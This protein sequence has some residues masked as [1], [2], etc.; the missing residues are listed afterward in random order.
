MMLSRTCVSTSIRYGSPKMMTS[1][2]S[3]GSPAGVLQILDLWNDPN[4]VDV[5]H[6]FTHET[7]HDTKTT[8]LNLQFPVDDFVLE[9]RD[10]DR[11]ALVPVLGPSDDVSVVLLFF[12][13]QESP[14]LFGDVRC[15]N[16]DIGL[17]PERADDR[18]VARVA[19]LVLLETPLVVP[20][21]VERPHENSH[22]EG[23][24]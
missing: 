4:E 23:H 18:E 14:T 21:A 22:G 7:R 17:V 24:Q 8:D 20:D 3:A 10:K 2:G 5:R 6:C 15:A 1:I 9:R 11:A 16:I 12:V 19:W 13:T